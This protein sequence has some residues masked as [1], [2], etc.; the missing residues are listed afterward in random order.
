[1][2]NRQE[3]IAW[4]RLG[5][6]RDLRE[7]RG[8]RALLSQELSHC[9][10]PHVH[11]G[12]VR[13]YGALIARDDD[14]SCLGSISSL[15]DAEQVR[16]AADAQNMLAFA[17]KGQ[18]L[19]LL[20]LKSP[21]IS[22]EDGVRLAA[23]ADGVV[24][25]VNETGVVWIASAEGVTTIDAHNAWSRPAASDVV[26]T[27]T[28]LV[29]TAPLGVLAAVATLAYSRLSPDRVGATLLLELTDED[30]T[31]RQSPGESLVDLNLNV[32]SPSDWPLIEHHLRHT[33]GAM[34]ISQD[35]RVLRRAVFLSATTE[36][37]KRTM[38]GAGTRH[39]SAYRHTFDRPDLLA[40]VISADG[41]VR[42][43]SDGLD[44]FTLTM[45]DG[46][47][48]WNPSGGEMWVSDATCPHCGVKLVVRK[49]ILY[50]WRDH[51]TEDCPVC[52]KEAASV[53]GW[54]VEIALVKDEATIA[55]IKAVRESAPSLG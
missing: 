54:R 42:V 37:Q 16:A 13:P 9:L 31:A 25:R 26:S 36:A 1:M 5:M 32:K 21:L 17:V 53:H 19:R 35:G 7:F 52:G 10:F 41:P 30:L 15:S 28:S 27:L 2:E 22:Q 6:Y 14:P 29:P 46:A 55:R 43:F 23:A 18:P 49:T 38:A 12:N 48:P 4:Q 24:V 45:P 51:E 8:L 39:N 33:D 3:V 50:G 20:R 47:L 40:F 11:E 34:V 44:A